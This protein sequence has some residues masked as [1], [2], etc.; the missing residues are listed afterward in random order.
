[1]VIL[2]R[3]VFHLQ[4]QNELLITHSIFWFSQ[5]EHFR[6]KKKLLKRSSR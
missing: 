3:V 1:M 6:K 4:K 2:A 5:V